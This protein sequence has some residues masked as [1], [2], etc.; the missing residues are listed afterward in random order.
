MLDLTC[1]LGFLGFAS[2][3]FNSILF[4]TLLLL[5][6]IDSALQQNTETEGGRQQLA[7]W[8]RHQLH[9]LAG[10]SGIAEQFLT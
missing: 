10:I 5:A 7:D 1:H 2:L 9:R 8:A 6:F 4:S 3:C